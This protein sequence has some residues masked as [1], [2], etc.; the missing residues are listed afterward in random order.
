MTPY[1][2]R[3]STR[4]T[5]GASRTRRFQTGSL[6]HLAPDLVDDV[7][8]LVDVGAVGDRDV[9]V[10]PRP[11]AG[12]VGGDLDLAVGDGVDDAVEVAERRPPQVE[13]LDRAVDAGEADHVALAELVLDQ[14][15]GAV[16]VVAD[17]ASG[18]RSPTAMP[19]TPSPATAGP[20]SR[21]SWPRTISAAMT[22]MK[23]WM[24]LAAEAVERVHPLLE[25]DRAQ[26]LGR[27]LG[28]LAV[29]Q[30]LDDAVDEQAG[31]P[32]RDE[33][34]DD[35]EQDRDER[36]RAAKRERSSLQGSVVEVGH[37]ATA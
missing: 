21:P 15:Q 37:R 29:E 3:A 35:D 9:L 25:L 2:P 14:D 5:R 36:R 12:Q 34:D 18:P 30:R 16:E 20:M 11:D 28:R 23:N 32:H 27:A 31:E 24:A 6:G 13:V 22:T 26:L 19:T 4:S 33:R 10:D 17:E 7:D 1:S 8:R